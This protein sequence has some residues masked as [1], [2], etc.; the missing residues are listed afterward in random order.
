MVAP[1]LVR[2]KLGC[3]TSLKQNVFL[4]FVSEGRDDLMPWPVGRGTVAAQIAQ[5]SRG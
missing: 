1:V 2:T 3:L 4:P 5:G